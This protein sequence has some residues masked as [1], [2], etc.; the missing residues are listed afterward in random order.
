M[1]VLQVVCEARELWSPVS[2]RAPGKNRGLNAQYQPCSARSPA[3]TAALT[4]GKVRR[5]PS[6][7]FTPALAASYDDQSSSQASGCAGDGTHSPVRSKSIAPRT[8]GGRLSGEC[9]R[10]PA[11]AQHKRCHQPRFG[12]I[13][14]LIRST[15]RRAD[16][17]PRV[18]EI[19][20]RLA[21]GRHRAPHQRRDAPAPHVAEHDDV[22]H[23]T[24]AS[25]QH[26]KVAGRLAI[27]LSPVTANS[28]AAL[29]PWWI[30]RLSNGGTRL[31]TGRASTRASRHGI[32]G[33]Q[34]PPN[35]R[36]IAHDE[37]V[38]RVRVHQHGRVHTRV[39]AADDL[40]REAPHTL[41]V[42]RTQPAAPPSPHHDLG[43]LRRRERT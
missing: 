39:A 32:L 9:A 13:W 6:D 43:A 11:R 25:A 7:T 2:N 35:A 29:V 17:H 20:C 15:R 16:L 22:L 12:H 24:P 38:S 23:L 37:E 42:I 14:V 36:A 27:A 28:S 3:D 18:D 1:R 21:P 26:D 10:Q 19:R 33:P 4:K 41:C 30:P 31:A 8:K 34:L 40:R 5:L